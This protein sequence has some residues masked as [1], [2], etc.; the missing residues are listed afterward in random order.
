MYKPRDVSIKIKKANLKKKKIPTTCIVCNCTELCMGHQQRLNSG[1]LDPQASS[2]PLG[3][4][5]Q[6]PAVG[7]PPPAGPADTR[8]R[9]NPECASYASTTGMQNSRVL[10]FPCRSGMGSRNPAARPRC[11]CEK[12]ALHTIA[13]TVLRCGIPK[14]TSRVLLLVHFSWH[15]WCSI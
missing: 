6:P 13:I 7:P 8:R 5:E 14:P 1:L 2:L 11:R 3:L 4:E 12:L 10:R 9:C 15:L